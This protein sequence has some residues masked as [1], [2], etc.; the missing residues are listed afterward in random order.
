MQRVAAGLLDCS[1]PARKWT[2]QAHYAATLWLMRHVP[3]LDLPTAMPDIIRRYNAATGVPNSDTRGYHATITLASLR[4]TRAFLDT[5]SCCAAVQ[6]NG[7]TTVGSAEVAGMLL[8]PQRSLERPL[9]VILSELMESPL[10]DVGWLLEHWSKDV[11]FTPEARRQWT[12]PDI[13]ALPF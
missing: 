2:H 4:A 10:G 7:N 1:L 11:L 5:H 8:H 12:E 6:S 13:K 3:S 9:H